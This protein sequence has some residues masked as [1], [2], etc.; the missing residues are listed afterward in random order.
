MRSDVVNL[1]NCRRTDPNAAANM[2]TVFY[3]S[4]ENL[5]LVLN[6]SCHAEAPGNMS[7]S[8]QDPALR[9]DNVMRYQWKLNDANIVMIC[10]DIQGE[11]HHCGEE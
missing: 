2:R 4:R 6:D 11:E 5:N 9:K 3:L 1:R 10:I 7:A 8:R